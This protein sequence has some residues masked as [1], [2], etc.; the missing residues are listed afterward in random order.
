MP[1]QHLNLLLNPAVLHDLRLKVCQRRVV[2][3]PVVPGSALGRKEGL[4]SQ[5]AAEMECG[6]ALFSA[7]L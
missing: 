6:A 3:L 7:L 4:R 2:H 5:G 1:E